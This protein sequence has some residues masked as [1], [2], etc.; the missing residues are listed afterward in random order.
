MAE[1]GWTDERMESVW[2]ICRGV[3]WNAVR[4]N[5]VLFATSKVEAE[6]ETDSDVCHDVRQF[7]AQQ[8]FKIQTISI[9][10]QEILCYDK[11][12]RGPVEP[13]DDFPNGFH[14][15]LPENYD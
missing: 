2:N 14:P 7:W 11:T 4:G 6:S 1:S 13:C 12:A 10:T 5:A 9:C 15:F 8:G 3:S